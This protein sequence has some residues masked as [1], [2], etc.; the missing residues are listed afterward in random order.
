M[1]LKKKILSFGILVLC[2]SCSFSS[3]KVILK[4]STELPPRIDL[5]VLKL[6]IFNGFA[7]KVEY[8][9]EGKFKEVQLECRGKNTGFDFTGAG[10]R[11]FISAPYKYQEEKFSCRL[12]TDK[13]AWTPIVEVTV[14]PYGYKQEFLKVPKKHVDLSKESID[15]WLKEKELLNQIYTNSTLDRAFFTEPFQK[16]LNSKITSTYGKRRVFNDKKDS[17]HSGIDFR[18][19]KPTPVPSSNRGK[20]AFAGNLFFNGNTVIL[21][22]GLGVFTMYCHLSK[23]LAQEGEILPKGEVLGL[24]GNTGRSSAPHLHWGVR[25]HDNWIN[26]FS[27]LDQGI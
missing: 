16:P 9:I 23:I 20:V 12:S 7:K 18:A 19:R 1:H 8:E 4:E 26:G 27:L 21:D 11:F 22:H 17:W 3:K 13:F 25:V 5:K 14:K 2:T 15:R 10:L 24:S 6:E